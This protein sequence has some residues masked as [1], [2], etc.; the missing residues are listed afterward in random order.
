MTTLTYKPL[1]FE[2]INSNKCMGRL[3][4]KPNKQCNKYP[5]KVHGPLTKGM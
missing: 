3:K 4:M 1:T 2:N 5:K